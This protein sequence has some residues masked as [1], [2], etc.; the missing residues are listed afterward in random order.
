M[1]R[2]RRR[3]GVTGTKRVAV[4]R[5]RARTRWRMNKD[6]YVCACTAVSKRQVTGLVF[7]WDFGTLVC[8]ELPGTLGGLG[9][10]PAQ[11]TA[12]A[13]ICSLRGLLGRRHAAVRGQLRATTRI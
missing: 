10:Q 6:T 7:F 5:V 2:H 1:L 9:L 8:P 11:A 12:P 4:E 3:G 13:A